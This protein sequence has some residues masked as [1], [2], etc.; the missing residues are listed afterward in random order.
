MMNQIYLKNGL[1]HH[2]HPLKFQRGWALG[3]N[4]LMGRNFGKDDI[5]WLDAPGVG[6][7]APTARF[8]MEAA[9]LFEAPVYE[10][11]WWQ[12]MV[13]KNPVDNHRLDGAKTL[14]IMG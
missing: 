13:R 12:L 1:F 8:R 3:F 5:F 9:G 4:R 6:S 2:V 11:V 7:L 14:L 10:R